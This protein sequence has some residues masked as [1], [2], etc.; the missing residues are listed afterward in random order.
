M[1]HFEVTYKPGDIKFGMT[2]FKT[3]LDMVKHFEERPLMTG[4]TGTTSFVLED[5]IL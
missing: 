1:K 2:A 3:V 4:E 5:I